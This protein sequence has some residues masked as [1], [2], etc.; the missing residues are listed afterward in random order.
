MSAVRR[1]PSWCVAPHIFGLVSHLRVA[2]EVLRETESIA[3]ELTQHGDDKPPVVALTHFVDDQDP[4]ISYL[5]KSEARELHAALGS[6][7]N[8]LD[9]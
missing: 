6:A 1:C 7:L 2:G 3:V 4:D 8:L 9:S 5:T